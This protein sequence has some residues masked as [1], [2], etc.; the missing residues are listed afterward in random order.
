MSRTYRNPSHVYYLSREE[1][2][3]KVTA[4][5][6]GWCLE[7]RSRHVA[8]RFEDLEKY[9]AQDMKRYDE[10]FRDGCGGMTESGRSQAFKSLCKK[11]R[12]IS[13]RVNIN[14]V[15]KARSEDVD[16]LD[17]D[18]QTDWH[19]KHHIWSVW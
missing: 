3:R 18:W 10:G 12:R 7:T 4:D 13:N 6:M 16:G 15:I 17:L 5:E 8:R 2:E 1:Y 14:K 9:I 11:E 19:G